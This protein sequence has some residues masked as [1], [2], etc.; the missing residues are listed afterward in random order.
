[1]TERELPALTRAEQELVDRYLRIIDLVA[2]LNPARDSGHFDA[3]GCVLAAQALAAE[4]KAIGG[5]AETM[6]E[7]G[8]DELH[9]ATLARAMRAL[10][11]ERRIARLRLPKS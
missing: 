11:G 4:A 1:M 3:R 8:E 9:A 6:L 7:R 10:D 5:A 2:R